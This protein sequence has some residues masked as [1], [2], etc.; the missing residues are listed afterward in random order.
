[1]SAFGQVSTRA[2]EE[3]H[4]GVRS[5]EA[6]HFE[7]AQQ[8]FEKAVALDPAYRYS[9]FLLAL[10]LHQQYRPGVQSGANIALAR[11]AISTY[12]NYLTIDPQNETA[13]GFVALV[14]S[15]K[16][17]YNDSGY[18]NAQSSNPH[19]KLSAPNVISSWLASSGIVHLRWDLNSLTWMRRVLQSPGGASWMAWSSLKKPSPLIPQTI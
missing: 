2:I 18:W 17:S 12:R 10:S 13:F 1:M 11:K 5:Y 15:G 6:G 9:Q 8:H 19:Q 7:A 14:S 4:A 3:L 16:M